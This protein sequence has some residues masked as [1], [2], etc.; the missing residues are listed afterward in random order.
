MY[1]MSAMTVCDATHIGEVLIFPGRFAESVYGQLPI[2]ARSSRSRGVHSSAAGR[3][4]NWSIGLLSGS[5]A[6]AAAAIGN[7]RRI[8]TLS[9]SNFA[10]ICRRRSRKHISS[11]RNYPPQRRRVREGELVARAGYPGAQ[12]KPASFGLSKGREPVAPVLL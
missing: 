12:P 8:R 5:Y 3:G 11:A 7:S 1:V 9:R 2:R 10:M 6:P 4:S